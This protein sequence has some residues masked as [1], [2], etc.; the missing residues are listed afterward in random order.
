MDE[1]VVKCRAFRWECS[2]KVRQDKRVR[3]TKHNDSEYLI[4]VQSLTQSVLDLEFLS[5][6]EEY[7]GVTKLLVKG[8][9]SPHRPYK[10]EELSFQSYA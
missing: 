9:H 5:T 2:L 6:L 4:E 8:G 3:C 7:D 1:W 10:E